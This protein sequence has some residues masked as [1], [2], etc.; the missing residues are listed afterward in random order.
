[1]AGMSRHIGVGQ[2]TNSFGPW[3]SIGLVIRPFDKSFY[4]KVRT[5]V[6]IFFGIFS[7]DYFFNY[8]FFWRFSQ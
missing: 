7:G 8:S 5:L 6:K 2:G 3:D 4:P 1:V